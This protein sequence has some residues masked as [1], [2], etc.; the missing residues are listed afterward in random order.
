MNEHDTEV[1][2]GISW[3]SAMNR[4][5]RRKMQTSFAQHV[6]DPGNAETKCLAK[7]AI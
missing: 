3:R 1:M 7:S 4:P 2:A 6:C 5:T